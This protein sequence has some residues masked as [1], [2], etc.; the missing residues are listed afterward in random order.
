M[1]FTNPDDS[2]RFHTAPWQ[3]VTAEAV[4]AEQLTEATEEEY[5]LWQMEAVVT[6]ADGRSLADCT[7]TLNG[8]PVT[9]RPQ[10]D[11]TL[12]F[13]AV[14]E[15]QSYRPVD[16]YGDDVG[17]V[18]DYEKYIAAYPEVAEECCWDEE[19]VLDYFFDEGVYV[20]HIGNGLFDPKEVIKLQPYVE[21]Y[22]YDDWMS[23]YWEFIS[24]GCDSEWL[25]ESSARFAPAVT[26]AP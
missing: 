14:Y 7:V 10:Q 25:A 6:A 12:L 15:D 23:Y 20:C 4:S 3:N 8:T 18:Y 24:W 26:D 21:D 17:L 13:S 5:A 19:A 9:V 22:L 11:G 16:Y 2:L 1:S